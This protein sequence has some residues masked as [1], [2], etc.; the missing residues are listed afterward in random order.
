MRTQEQH[1]Q[2]V[3]LRFL[4]YG[5]EIGA[6]HEYQSSSVVQHVDEVDGGWQHAA[7]DDHQHGEV[8]VHSVEQ[9]VKSQNE[10]DQDD[11]AQQVADDAE[12]EEQLVSA[13]VARRHGRVPTHEQFGGNVDKAEGGEEDKEQVQESGDSPWVAGRAHVPSAIRAWPEI[14]RKPS[15]SSTPRVKAAAVGR[16]ASG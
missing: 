4:E 14:R 15:K 5:Q 2:G 6:A 9:P 7:E 10:K 16:S 1:G 12:A 11:P 8:P 3:A 13:D